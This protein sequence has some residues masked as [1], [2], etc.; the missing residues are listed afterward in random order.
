MCIYAICGSLKINVLIFFFNKCH[1]SP[2]IRGGFLFKT[3]VAMLIHLYCY[4]DRLAPSPGFCSCFLPSLPRA[5]IFPPWPLNKI[6]QNVNTEPEIWRY[7][8]NVKSN[9]I[10]CTISWF[11]YLHNE[12]MC[13]QFWICCKKTWWWWWYGCCCLLPSFCYWDNGIPEAKKQVVWLIATSQ[14]KR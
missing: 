14:I 9:G 2:P 6:L 10:I 13:R 5:S 7:W 4:N 1:K 8:E 3:F 11:Y 12:L